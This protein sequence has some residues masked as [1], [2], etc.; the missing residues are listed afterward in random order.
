MGCRDVS[1][2]LLADL[3]RH[4]WPETL[5]QLREIVHTVRLVIIRHKTTENISWFI[6][7]VYKLRLSI[8]VITHTDFSVWIWKKISKKMDNNIP[9]PETATSNMD[10]KMFFL[11]DSFTSRHLRLGD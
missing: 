6:L 1:C 3:D 11:F 10:N 7:V 2:L 5:P 9:G 4:N 8:S